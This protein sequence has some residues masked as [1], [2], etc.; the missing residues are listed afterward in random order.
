MYFLIVL[1]LC[2]GGFGIVTDIMGSDCII[3]FDNLPHPI[4]PK[5]QS[6]NFNFNEIGLK[7]LSHYNRK[8][9]QPSDEMNQ[10]IISNSNDFLK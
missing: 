7:K 9:A 3:P 5:L 8:L 4:K 6:E 10:T 1:F 2:Q